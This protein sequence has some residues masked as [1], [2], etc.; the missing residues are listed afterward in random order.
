MLAVLE[1]LFRCYI[2]VEQFLQ[3]NIEHCVEYC[4]QYQVEYGIEYCAALCIECCTKHC[5]GYCINI[6]LKMVWII[7]LLI[8]PSIALCFVLRVGG[9]CGENY[10][11]KE[12]TMQKYIKVHV[13]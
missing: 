6:V 10:I 4:V 13:C 12:L 1:V 11:V 8:G 3:Y 7:A 2:I 9:F 5:I